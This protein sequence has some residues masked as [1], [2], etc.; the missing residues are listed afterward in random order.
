MKSYNSIISRVHIGIATALISAGAAMVVVAAKPGVRSS[1]VDPTEIAPTADNAIVNRSIP[2][3]GR[4][5]AHVPAA[6]VPRPTPLA[7]VDPG[8]ELGLNF[9][10]LNFF[11]QRF[12]ADGGNQFSV[13]PP[14]QGLC[15]GNGLVLEAVNTVLAFYDASTGAQIGGFESLNQF[16]TG[17][18][19]VLRS[20]PPVF[21]TF[22]TD[23]KCIYDAGSG[24]FF[25][26]I[27]TIG[28]DP[29]TGAFVPPFT[30]RIAT[31][32]TS[33]PTVNPSDWYFTTIDV[34]ND[35]T[36]GTPTHPGCPCVGDQP[37]IGADANGFYIT[38]NEFPFFTSGFNGAQ[39][40]ALQKS[41]LIAGTTP[42]IQRIE[43]APISPNYGEGIP[44]SLQP[45]ISP[46][47]AD[48]AT[49]SGGTE[50]LLGALE[51]GK[52]PFTLDNRI[53]VWAL[54]N[55]S[56]LNS[57]PAITVSTKVIPSQV[58]GLPGSI[59]QPKGPTPLADA[60]KAHENLI[61]GG[62]D[63]MQAA[64]YAH[65]LLWGAGDTVVKTPT[66]S[67]QVGVTYYVVSP[68]VTGSAVD[69]TVVKQGYLSVDGNSV[70]RPSLGVTS[71][72]KAVIGVSL[73]GPDYFPSAAYATLDDT[74]TTAPSTLH[75]VAAGTKPA[76]G[77][78]GY[79]AFGFSGVERWGDYG[80]ASAVGN[81][82][83]I[84]N[85]LIQGNVSFPPALANWNTFVSKITP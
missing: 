13:E 52:R 65:G 7:V 82:V 27:V 55:T 51:F 16:F 81:D 49:G 47:A 8:T 11:N 24:R 63:R 32:K 56:S 26:T 14:D 22:I 85:E 80:A 61:D 21:G 57:T 19:A 64:T 40:Y 20:T 18:H 69:G 53:A 71:A 36:N 74:L 46:S 42:N 84:A 83:W 54:T 28:Q 2:G 4:S 12:D 78:T 41:A 29:S 3:G 76:D 43:G 48:F 62:D 38:T 66:G 77:F 17:D 34:T 75:V 9:S 1:G 60:V 23:P 15:V 37:L 68:S 10:G 44:Y 33:T 59:V 70:T 79:P 35:G 72:G 39:I 5:P 45:A 31:S 67:S 73:V 25:M 50:Y 6:F 30:V 58:Y